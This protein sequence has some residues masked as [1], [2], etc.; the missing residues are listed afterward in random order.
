[1][2]LCFDMTKLRSTEC[3]V[4][5]SLTL[6][7]LF[8]TLK[9]VNIFRCEKLKSLWSPSLIQSLLHL[10]ELQVEGCNELKTV[11]TELENDGGD[12]TESSS[13]DLHLLC[14][15]KLI[16]L[17]IH[18]CPR[19][20]YVIPMT[21]A[22]G[23]LPRLET[24]DVSNCAILKQVFG[25][26]KEQ[27]G[28][29]CRIELPCLTY[30]GLNHLTNLRSFGPKHYIFKPSAL[31]NLSVFGCPQLMKYTSQEEVKTHWHHLQIFKFV[32][33]LKICLFGK[34]KPQVGVV[35][36]LYLL[37]P[38]SLGLCK[39]E[40]FSFS[41]PYSAYPPHPLFLLS[42]QILFLKKFA[43]IQKVFSIRSHNG[44]IQCALWGV[45]WV[46]GKD[47]WAFA[48]KW[49]SLLPGNCGNEIWE[50]SF[51]AILWSLRT[52]R[53]DVIFWNKKIDILLVVD[54]I[55][56][57][58]A[59]WAKAKWPDIEQGV[60]DIFRFLHCIRVPHKDKA[61]WP[62]SVWSVPP[63]GSV[64]FNVDGSSLGKSGLAGIGGT[65]QDHRGQELIRFS[66]HIGIDGGEFLAIRE[67]S[68]L[69]STSRWARLWK[70]IQR[71]RL[72]GLITHLLSPWRLRHL[73]SHIENLKV[74]TSKL[75]D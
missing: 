74:T 45:Q 10:E 41:S 63:F 9:V 57:R 66:K 43:P 33:P 69:F 14:L 1:M 70:V 64:K 46:S 75:V 47:A 54:L 32:A 65:L 35:K 68:I 23:G 12:Q 61:K 15:P 72:V 21:L 8:Q 6:S 58:I 22:Q 51:G 40:L 7:R 26:A 67:A 5:K 38:E 17:R 50:M 52:L 73:V 39:V 4:T 11:F 18:S 56:I 62:V 42:F 60:N 13:H 55:K 29:E 19:L 24:I 25:V 59:L 48:G 37:Y 71:M 30:L 3:I 2:V 31:K 28:V 49:F 53:N 16:T 44:R 20:E 34:W 36:T 27:D